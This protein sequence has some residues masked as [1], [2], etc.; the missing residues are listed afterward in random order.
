MR[1]HARAVAAGLDG[2]AGVRRGPG[3]CAGPAVSS[4]HRRVAAQYAGSGGRDLHPDRTD[5]HSVRVVR[6]AD[7]S[8]G[9]L[10]LGC[11]GGSPAR[12]AALHHLLRMGVA[13]G[14]AGGLRRCFAGNHRGLHPVRLSPRG[15]RSARPRSGARGDG[16]GIGR[17]AGALLPARG[18]AATAPGALGGRAAGRAQHAGRVRRLHAAA[19]P[20][21]HHRAVRRIP[22]RHGWR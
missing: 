13:V 14:L 16:A 9:A 12:R 11:V 22:D 2:A 6:R 3:G 7:G 10:G 18:P 5:R 17:W 4:A 21:L 8:A 20:H 19:L 15:G 1:A